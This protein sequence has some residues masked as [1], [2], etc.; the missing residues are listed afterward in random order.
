MFMK[1]LFVKTD[2][3]FLEYVHFN[4]SIRSNCNL[5]NLADNVINQT[6]Y[7]IFNFYARCAHVLE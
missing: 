3:K 2:K 5:S 6:L 7:N 4:Y 1:V